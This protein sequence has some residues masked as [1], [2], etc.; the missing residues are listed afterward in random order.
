M[1]DRIE[2][3]LKKFAGRCDYL[4]ARIEEGEGTG[5]S[6]RGK[7]IDAIRESL[8]LGGCVRAYHK[9]GV[10][11]ASFNNL[12]RIPEF[13]EKA[14]AQAAM[15]GSGTTRLAEAPVVKGEFKAKVKKDPRSVPLGEKMAILQGY[16]ELIL[17]QDK[18][19]PTSSVG[20]GDSFR[21]V[22]FG[23]SEGTRVVYEKVDI[24]CN[25]TA[26]AV[27]D[28][29]TQ[30]GG[31]GCGSSDDFDCVLGHEEE[32]KE[33]CGNALA[34]LD[35]PIVKG[36]TYTAVIDPHL[37]GVF[38]HE[39]FGHMSEGEKV[40]F[41]PQLAEILKIGK[42]LG[43]SVLNIYDT[44]LQPGT[45]GAIPF[46]EE[47]VPSQRTDLIRA[48]ILV[49]RLHSRET[50]GRMNEAATGS[51]RA[52][53]HQFPPV[54]RMRNT[55]IEG[56]SASFGEMIADVDDG[57]YALKARGG[58]AGEMF[59]FTPA[60]CYMIRKGKVEEM[61]KGAI[62]S[63]NL[64]TTLKNIDMVGADFFLRDSG[65]GCGK[66][67]PEGF[68]FPLPVSHGAPHIRIRNVV[69]GGR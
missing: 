20:Y 41:N 5:I 61:V 69:I 17:S 39:A 16:N 65:G 32:L 64:F 63:G 60:R 28:G 29:Q 1:M 11:F 25:L 55:C 3:V 49:G 52:I 35:A 22:H 38:V 43:S 59:S 50:A 10:G 36:G 58:Q 68:Q 30:F 57:I 13:A 8:S 27:A 51:A 9:G 45:R 31:T 42:V 4:E 46:D 34:L 54:P 12:K 48:G 23:N 14:I 37:A 7:S 44:G 19:I 67:T 40:A 21:K 56:G 47:G 2:D 33:E 15:V 26:I 53:S 62:L 18:R 6:L 24:G 66:G